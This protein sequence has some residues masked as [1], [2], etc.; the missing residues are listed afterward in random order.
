[1]V[2]ENLPA[3]DQRIPNNSPPLLVDDKHLETSLHF[4]MNLV[5]RS[6]EM[7]PRAKIEVKVDPAPATRELRAKSKFFDGKTIYQKP[8]TKLGPKCYPRN[9]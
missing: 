7:L 8:L 4:H 3:K 9:R 1:M 6:D 2:P 5:Y